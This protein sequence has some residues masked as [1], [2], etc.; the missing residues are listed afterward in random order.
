MDMPEDCEYP[1]CCCDVCFEQRWTDTVRKQRKTNP[2][3]IFAPIGRFRVGDKVQVVSDSFIS[4]SPIAPK[5]EI[6]KVGKVAMVLN[7]GLLVIDFD[8]HVGVSSGSYWPDEV[9]AVND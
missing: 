6:G 9:E 4:D 2:E 5:K 1:N 8:S 3:P 7:D